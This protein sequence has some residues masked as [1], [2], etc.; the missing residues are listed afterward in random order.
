M[1][2]SE[3]IARFLES[4]PQA[5]EQDLQKKFKFSYREAK[6]FLGEYRGEEDVAALEE[7]SF[8]RGLLFDI[9]HIFS[10]PKKTVITL[11]AIA[12]FWRF[13]YI[14]FFAS[15]PVLRI[16]LLDAEYYLKWADEI[17]SQGWLGQRVFFT[18]PFYAY[19]LALVSTFFGRD[20][21]ALVTFG[22]QF[23]LGVL[24]PVLLYFFGRTILSEKVGRIAGL[25]AAFYGPFLFYEGLLL[26]TSFEVYT[27]PVF[28]LIFWN[29]LEK[30]RA[31]LFVLSGVALGLVTLIK[32][33]SMVFLPLGLFLIFF[34]LK[35]IERKQ[36]YIYSTL[37]VVGVL[38][39][40][41]PITIRNYVVAKDIVPTN[42]SIG[43]VLYQ[44]NWWGGDGST[45]RVPSF[46][47]PHPKYEETD[48]V[49][50]AES[51]EG[52]ELKASEVSRFWMRKTV[53]EVLAVP[54]HF[55]QS[56]GH[57]ILLL[58]NYRDYSDNY[59]YAYYRSQIPFLWILPGFLVVVILGI[60][61]MFVFFGRSFERMLLSEYKEEEKETKRKSLW[62]ARWM[63]GLLFAG[64]VGVL[65]LTTINSRYR[66]P[67]VP[68]L[69]VFSGINI[70]FFFECYYERVSK[71]V[72]KVL[73]VMMVTFVLAVLP[74]AIFKHLSFADAY[75]NIGYWYFQKGDYE[76]AQQYFQKAVKDDKE[77]AWSF[78]GMFHIALLDGRYD[79][80]T[81]HL[82]KLI[83]IRSDDLS[84]YDDV[85][86]LKKVEKLSK[87]E[88]HDA[89]EEAI[90][91]NE[92]VYD[93][94]TYEALR[95][96]AEGE[97]GDA[98]TLLKQSLEKND[99][100]IAALMAMANLKTKEGNDAEA[101]DY[102]RKAIDT[103]EDLFVAR[104]N[105]ANIYIRSN[106]YSQISELLGPVYEFA[107]ELGETWYN[108]AVALIR[109]SKN[110]EAMPVAEAY[111][112]RYKDDATRKDKVTKLQ[113]FVDAAKKNQNPAASALPTPGK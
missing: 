111:V 62:K 6:A 110:N 21:L 86:L 24:F 103:N 27:L 102:L 15:N 55:L 72:W 71:G 112:E 105:L 16:P 4:H 3:K 42:Y 107:P 98:E 73:A 91:K 2:R 31:R 83:A 35:D 90:N 81:V 79:D 45:A 104:Y 32:G 36:K 56:F 1:R 74:L 101:K 95:L 25:L 38:L 12:F 93:V 75:H 89:V 113:N 17:L 108:Y 20:S 28:L 70:A 34:L 11:I 51:F 46:L 9:R 54:V 57:K 53:S 100:S 65:L 33:N 40:I 64:Y 23:L 49:N 14:L 13:F 67:L 44:G 60:G 77:Y 58:L 92:A 19:F 29:A 106:D 66:M 61:G 97:N 10:S 52:R 87:K 96:L 26:K 59:S 22:I 109:T 63:L 43:L 69:M 82:Q 84:L 76:Q 99:H 41:L 30:P 88:S 39:C 68:F 18:E 37:Y 94:S 50:M 78:R 85:A 80:A 8:W 48:A 5:T 7:A 47:R